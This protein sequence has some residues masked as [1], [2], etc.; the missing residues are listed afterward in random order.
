MS[1]ISIPI[2]VCST[3]YTCPFS[4]REVLH[5]GMDRA[6][7]VALL[8]GR[9]EGVGNPEGSSIP[10]C[11]IRQLTHPFAPGRISDGLGEFGILN[12]IRH[13]QMFDADRLALTDQL[14][15]H[16]V[17]KIVPGICNVFVNTSNVLLGFLLV[18]APWCASCQ[19]PLPQRKL[20]L[21]LTVKP[22][23]GKMFAVGA[24]SVF[25]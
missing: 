6:A 2:M 11:F 10:G 21:V 16:L 7:Y 18:G 12:H 5:F 8:T 19:T 25:L 14:R 4:N 22:G 1:R 20:F 3:S 15:C 23:V 13:M 9:L 17:E 24:H